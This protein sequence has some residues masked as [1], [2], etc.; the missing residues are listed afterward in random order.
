MKSSEELFVRVRASHPAKGHEVKEMNKSS[1]L[2]EDFSP[3]QFDADSNSL[4]STFSRV[5]EVM[6]DDLEGIMKHFL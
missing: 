6:D 1:E 3:A 5:K 4:K 2:K